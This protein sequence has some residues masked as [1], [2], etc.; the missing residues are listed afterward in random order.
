[1]A[2]ASAA[3]A[4][5]LGETAVIRGL[6]VAASAAAVVGA[7]LM[8][9][10]DRAAGKRVAELTKEKTRAEWRAEERAAELEADVEEARE[11]RADL[12]A[13]LRAKRAE[14]ARLRNEHADLLRRYATA[15]TERARA[16]ESRRRLVRDAVPNELPAPRRATAGESV[17]GEPVVGESVAA[18]SVADESVADKSVVAEDVAREA[19]AEIP[20]VA[21]PLD[22][23]AFRRAAAALRRLSGEEAS[24]GEDATAGEATAGDAADAD[25]ADGDTTAR[26]TIAGDVTDGDTTAGDVTDAAVIAG[27]AAGSDAAE[28]NAADSDARVHTRNVATAVVPYSAARRAIA[29]VEG[30]FDFF[31]T[32]KSARPTAPQEPDAPAA[33]GA[34]DEDLADVVGD[35]ALAEQ[36]RQEEAGEVID[37]TAHDETEQIDM[38]EL[39]SAIS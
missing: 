30:G 25:R 6:A 29:R 37:L 39:R 7:F 1:M 36:A 15:E 3:G 35:E 9:G 13:K 18:E 14:L 17:V 31:G 24:G 32:Q 34:V 16:L 26:D 33:A 27:G 19:S 28:G 23:E 10:W 11:V 21:R 5:V 4:L 20:A 8:R 12:N 38:G 22:A 2:I